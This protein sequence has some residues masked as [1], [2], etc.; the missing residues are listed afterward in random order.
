MKIKKMI[1]TFGVEYLMKL[2]IKLDATR[3]C[4]DEQMNEEVWNTAL[5]LTEDLREKRSKKRYLGMLYACELLK[6]QNREA[7]IVGLLHGAVDCSRYTF[8]GLAREEIPMSVIARLQILQTNEDEDY[9]TYIARVKQDRMAT[10]VK[11]KELQAAVEFLDKTA[12]EKAKHE[13][14]LLYLI[15]G[16]VA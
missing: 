15:N 14:A 4:K 3:A 7:C 8:E 6:E 16:D 1:A 9:M 10:A 13:S 12:E 11:I 5:R 2:L